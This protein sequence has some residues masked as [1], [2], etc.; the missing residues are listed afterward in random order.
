MSKITTAETFPKRKVSRG[1]N[2]GQRLLPWLFPFLL[3]LIWQI[4]SSTGLLQSR[5]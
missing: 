1:T 2:F 4:A 3:I 5:I